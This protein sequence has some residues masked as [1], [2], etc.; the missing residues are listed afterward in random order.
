[1]YL[2]SIKSKIFFNVLILTILFAFILFNF[3]SSAQAY[4][5]IDAG[6]RQVKTTDSPVVYYLDHSRGQK[7][8]YVNEA[9][10]LAYGNKW[11]DIKIIHPEL[12]RAWSDVS[13]VKSHNRPEVFYIENNTKKWIKSEEEFI[14]NGYEWSEIVTIAQTDLDQYTLIGDSPYQNKVSEQPIAENNLAVLT[15]AQ[16]VPSASL[17][18]FSPA[19]SGTAGDASVLNN[20]Q[21]LNKGLT[22]ESV[23]SEEG[24]QRTLVNTNNNLA[25][26]FKLRAFGEN[27]KIEKII[28]DVDGVFNRSVVKN[29]YLQLDNNSGEKHEGYFSDNREVYFNFSHQ[30]ISVLSGR[31]RE[32]RVYVDFQGDQSINFQTAR[33]TIQ[34]KNKI[35]TAS[36]VYGN[37]PLKAVNFEFIYLENLLGQAQ[38]EK[39]SL[40]RSLEA[41]IGA[42]EEELL[43]F[44]ITETSGLEN[45]KISKLVFENKGSASQVDMEN[46]VLKDSRG[47]S[48]SQA[49]RAS[50]QTIEFNLG[51]Y[52]IKKDSSANFSVRADIIGGENKTINL[53]LKE[54]VI[55]G[56][57]YGYFIAPVYLDFS[58]QIKIIREKLNVIPND[59]KVGPNVF[60]QE[61]GTLIGV[62][63]IR[64][65]NQS[66]FLENIK[67]SLFKSDLAPALTETVYLVNYDTGELYG[68]FRPNY[69]GFLSINLPKIEVGAKKNIKLALISAIPERAQQGDRY[70]SELTSISYRTVA[71]HWYFEDIVNIAGKTA[72]VSRSELFI[73]GNADT[74]QSFRIK[75]QK[76]AKVASFYLEAA[77]GD[78]VLING[79]TFAKGDSFGLMT[80]ENGFSN[81]KLKIG[82]RQSGNIIARP[83]SNTYDFSGFSYSLRSGQRV[84]ISVYADIEK[85]S[86]VNS[87]Q[88]MLSKISAQSKTSGATVVVQGLNAKS[89][90]VNFGE[91][92]ALISAG[93]NGSLNPGEKGNFAGSFTISNTGD[94][95]IRLL[96]IV[97]LTSG[98]GFSSSLG[99]RNLRIR[100]SG[101][102]RN[103]GS[104]VS[105]VSGA[106]KLSLN[107]YLLEAGTERT[108]EVYVDVGE[109]D[110]SSGFEL[111]FSEL[112]AEGEKSKISTTIV[113]APTRSIIVGRGSSSP[114]DNNDSAF[115][116][117]IRPASGRISTFFH[118]PNYIY[119]SEIGDHQGIDIDF[120][121]GTPVKAAADG[122]IFSVFKGGMNSA[123]YVIINHE[124]GYRTLYA[125]LSVINVRSGDSVKAGDIIGLGG[126]TPGTSGA[127]PY[128]NGPHLHF[129][130]H[131]NGTP[132]DPMDYLR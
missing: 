93:S 35:Q 88:L 120:A 39:L 31:E 99:Y 90:T 40:S 62:Y 60:K 37:F 87:A 98:D 69:G 17:P 6:F 92:K 96:D 12:L 73:Y 86:R 72:I 71:D 41:K 102:S 3:T 116:R 11:S 111:R 125:H 21:V 46:F 70:G 105:P 75:G 8:A 58:E 80:Y 42:V 114:I 68:S 36:Q 9:S 78:D 20:Q 107:R 45:L 30:P 57:S 33:F 127:G 23:I 91:V 43:V 15:S 1:M 4:Y 67:I 54:A 106:N 108:F 117:I 131:Y 24:K 63:E 130:L 22:V 112:N 124:N 26:A 48:I 82:N 122:T 34:N 115:F 53:R 47:R 25:S 64:T 61:N 79:L 7:K 113:G 81:I 128:S 110:R 52:N 84:E 103:I 29:I 59:L 49:K 74:E 101:S 89:Y 10:F 66:V 129:E 104:K 126:G 85:G 32:V 119:Q 94:E 38:I 77:H 121:Q 19:F 27:V 55:A 16:S 132:V 56:D 109:Y 100:E 118:D 97:L 44:K 28:L 65:N 13:L 51:D 14:K 2:S 95:N 76:D 50:G 5:G 18:D 83:Y 123:S